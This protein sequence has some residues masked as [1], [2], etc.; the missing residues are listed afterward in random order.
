MRNEGFVD[1]NDPNNDDIKKHLM[2]VFYHWLRCK[3]RRNMSVEQTVRYFNGLRDT[4]DLVWNLVYTREDTAEFRLKSLY[5]QATDPMWLDNL[6]RARRGGAPF[7]DFEGVR[8]KVEIDHLFRHNLVTIELP[9]E[10]HK[11]KTRFIDNLTNIPTKNVTRKPGIYWRSR[12][13]KL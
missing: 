1:G 4:Q 10:L 11:I 5:N 12:V 7:F 6:R 3:Q 2:F 9:E 13:D 8:K